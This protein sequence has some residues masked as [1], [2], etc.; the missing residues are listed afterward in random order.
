MKT[1]TFLYLFTFSTCTAQLIMPVRSVGIT[2]LPD[3][4][5]GVIYTQYFNHIGIYTS[6]A[7][8]ILDFSKRYDSSQKIS[9]GCQY[10]FFNK[11]SNYPLILSLGTSY[12][13]YQG[14]RTVYRNPYTLQPFDVQAGFGMMLNGFNVG[15][16]YD[17]FKNEAMVDVSWNIGKQLAKFKHKRR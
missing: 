2:V 6:Y 11:M 8:T 17:V 3:Y 4:G 1:L 13:T 12:N 9:F 15:F 16:R 7:H 10:L 14:A 5:L